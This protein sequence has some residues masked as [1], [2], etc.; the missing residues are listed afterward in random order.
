M[1]QDIMDAT[2]EID[3]A[4][5]PDSVANFGGCFLEG[6]GF[7]KFPSSYIR[8]DDIRINEFVPLR[9]ISEEFL[10]RH[11]EKN[12]FLLDSLA[13]RCLRTTTPFIWEEVLTL[14]DREPIVKRI[15]SEA[16]EFGISQG[17]TVP[18]RSFEGLIGCVTFA[19]QRDG[20][21]PK[22]RLELNILAQVMHARV[23]EVCHEP[24]VQAAGR[25]LSE[26]E[27]ETLKW[28]AAGKTSSEIASILGLTK[29]T[30]DQHFD[31]A[32]RK[33]GTVNRVHTVVMALKHNIIAL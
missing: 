11:S 16:G 3:E 13:R 4:T 24:S 10:S 1:K 7:S 27:R 32:A 19:G 33:L 26:R 23:A 31:N 2:T 15:Y 6:L 21:G 17:M 25:R 18:M 30:V 5:R 20:F 12:N 9:N 29:R 22:E 28:G 14:R 8:N